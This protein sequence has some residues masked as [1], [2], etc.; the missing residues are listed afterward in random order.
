M[1][2][3]SIQQQM[4]VVAPSSCFS[5]HSWCRND[6][7]GTSIIVRPLQMCLLKV[8]RCKLDTAGCAAETESH[9]RAPRLRLAPRRH[10]DAAEQCDLNGTE[11]DSAEYE[12]HPVGS[13]V[14]RGAD[15]CC[16]G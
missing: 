15:A 1:G 7:T 2:T 6:I 11:G 5:L 3:H 13:S 8:P 12:A 4:T 10:G 16:G 14:R 9:S